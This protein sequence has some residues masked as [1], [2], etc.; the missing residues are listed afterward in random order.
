MEKLALSPAKHATQLLVSSARKNTGSGRRG[1]SPSR[2]TAD[3]L[4]FHHFQYGILLL[5]SRLSY[6]AFNISNYGVP[7]TWI[8]LNN[9]STVNLFCNTNLLLDIS[10]MEGMMD[11]RYKGSAACTNIIN[12]LPDFY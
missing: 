4:G 3:F 7:R 11:I 10:E 8:L 1:V 6:E 2:S 12:N 9:Q 5:V